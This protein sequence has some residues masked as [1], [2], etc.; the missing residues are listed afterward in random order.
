MH[1]KILAW[2]VKNDK[3]R[4]FRPIQYVS[5]ELKFGIVNLL[6]QSFILIKCLN[7]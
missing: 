2:Y 4:K 3:N 6:D 7:D 5:I 1:A